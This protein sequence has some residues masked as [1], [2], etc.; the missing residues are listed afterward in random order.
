MIITRPLGKEVDN[1][2]DGYCEAD[3]CIYDLSG[4]LIARQN[5]PYLGWCHNTL[6]AFD[7]D[8]IAP[9]GW[10]AYLGEKAQWIGSSEV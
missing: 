1:V 5:S 7:Y 6:E 4:E 9:F 8:G 2:L 10:V 3:L